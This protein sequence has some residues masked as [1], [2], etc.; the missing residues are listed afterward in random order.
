MPFYLFL[1]VESV[2][3][4]YVPG[5]AAQLSIGPQSKHGTQLIFHMMLQL[6]AGQK[7]TTILYHILCMTSHLI[8]FCFLF[9]PLLPL[10]T[11]LAGLQWLS[12]LSQMCTH[13]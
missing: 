1:F 13:E 3:L 5:T 9:E 12:T 8:S 6:R 7:T 2:E 10:N 11:A 4:A